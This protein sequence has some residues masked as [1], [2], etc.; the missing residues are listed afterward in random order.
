MLKDQFL[1][2]VPEIRMISLDAIVQDRND[3]TLAGV[4]S[5]PGRLDVHIEAPSSSSV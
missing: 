5:S 2:I 4:A 1:S 3:N